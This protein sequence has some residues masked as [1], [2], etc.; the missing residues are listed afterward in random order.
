MYQDLP[1]L[2]NNRFY[3]HIVV[4]EYFVIDSGLELNDSTVYAMNLHSK[5]TMIINKI[6]RVH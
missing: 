4:K 1:G 3:N 2:A 5:S 6:N